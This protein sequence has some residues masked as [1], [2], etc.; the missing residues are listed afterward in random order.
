MF[1]EIF[2]T[3]T[4]RH[5]EGRAVRHVKDNAMRCERHKEAGFIY[6]CSSFS[7]MSAQF[8]KQ[9]KKQLTF[10]NRSFG[11]S[12]GSLWQMGCCQ[13]SGELSVVSDGI[14]RFIG[15]LKVI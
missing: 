11:S 6:F 10:R 8:K 7:K 1:S 5:D 13:F 3:V 4:R 15:Q 12:R 14:F 2:V 9:T